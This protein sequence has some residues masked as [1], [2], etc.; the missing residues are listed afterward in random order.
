MERNLRILILGA[1]GAA[2]CASGAASAGVGFPASGN[3]SLFGSYMAA[4][5][6]VGL[7]PDGGGGGVQLGIS[8]TPIF[9]I[10]GSYQYDY[11]YQ[12][13]ANSSSFADLPSGGNISY[14]EKVDDGRAG[15]GVVFHL[16]ATPIDV[17]GKVEYVH[18]D[19]Q[20]VHGV[21]NGA[22]I[23]DGARTNDDGVG[24][25]GGA[26]IKLPLVSVYG[27]LG[28]VDLSHNSGPEINLGGEL[29]I[30]PLTW[31]FAEYRYDNFH[32]GDIGVHTQ[33]NDVRA[34]VRLVF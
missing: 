9:F 26:Q 17:F 6:N 32:D 8:L 24:W 5:T 34:G 19:Y 30:A 25:H 23:A 33:F 10:A 20:Y 18:F 13:N 4:D 14:G 21:L 22:G 15:G 12:S 31:L 2:L 1:A 7:S 29:P 27:S 16:P 3:V 28:Y 11:L